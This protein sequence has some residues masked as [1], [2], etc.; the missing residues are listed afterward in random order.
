MSLIS[1]GFYV[2]ALVV[3]AS[4]PSKG[5]PAREGDTGVF[6]PGARLMLETTRVPGRDSA[7]PAS[8]SLPD[9]SSLAM[10]GLWY[11]YVCTITQ[12]STLGWKRA[13]SHQIGEAKAKLEWDRARKSCQDVGLHV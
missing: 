2:F 4:A 11:I 7:S 12:W 5:V 8:V 3:Q 10:L 1:I 13:W 9:Y 6:V